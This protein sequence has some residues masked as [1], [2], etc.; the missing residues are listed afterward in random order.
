[1][2]ELTKE[3][4]EVSRSHFATLDETI[5]ESQSAVNSR[6]QSVTSKQRIFLLGIDGMTRRVDRFHSI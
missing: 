5:D 3:E 6:S 4:A 2:F 1:M